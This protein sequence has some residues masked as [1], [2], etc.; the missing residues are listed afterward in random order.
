LAKEIEDVTG[1]EIRV[2]VPGHFQRGG[3][4]CPFDRTLATRLGAAA[5]K[6]TIQKQFGYMVALKGDEIV[7][8][9]LDEV[10][11]KLKLVP[12]NCSIVQAAREIGVCF[13][14]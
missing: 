4:P 1:Q 13:G 11:G 9:P 2:T 12:P 6:L 5:A 3:S 10:A 14:D 7:P 8:V